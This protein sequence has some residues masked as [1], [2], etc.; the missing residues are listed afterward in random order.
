MT[1]TAWLRL[2]GVLARRVE[3]DSS[4]TGAEC[5]ESGKSCGCA[6]LLLLGLFHWGRLLHLAGGEAVLPEHQATDL[7][8]GEQSWNVHR[9]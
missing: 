2:L 5:T 7:T 6:F 3:L 4:L 8:D 1:A 9:D